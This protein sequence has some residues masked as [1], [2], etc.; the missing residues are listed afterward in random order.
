MA[1]YAFRKIKDRFFFLL[2][3][4]CVVLAVIPLGSILLEVIV[5]GLPVLNWSFLTSGPAPLGQPGGGVGPAIQGTMLL[6]ALTSAIGVPLGVVSGV[7]LAEFGTNRYAQLMRMFNDVL[8]EFPSIVV[9]VTV[10]LTV[11]VVLGNF[12]LIAGSLALSFI[13]VPI[14][15]RTTEEAIKLVPSSVR[16]ASLALGVRRWRTTVSV[17]LTAAKA[18][19][20]TGVLLA[21]SRIAGET[22]PLIMTI[23]GNSHFFV[24][25]SQPM[26][27]LPLR[28]WRDSL[29]P[30]PVDQANGWGAALVLIIMVLGL[31]VAVRLAARGRQGLVREKI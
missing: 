27:A 16:E 4:A 21:L 14:V 25:F 3:A 7:Y 13:M 31:N 9:G 28:I 12:S 17:V 30:S 11:V 1:S 18:G 22:A 6:V 10:F 19:L 15:A 26:D 20:V 29:L 5:R 2:G 24:G 8:T 23:L